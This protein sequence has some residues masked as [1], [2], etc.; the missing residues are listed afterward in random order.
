M[1]VNEKKTLEDVL[2]CPFR[3]RG[4]VGN[5]RADF[6]ASIRGVQRYSVS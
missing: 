2:H 1:V 6:N 5:T 4:E 3:I